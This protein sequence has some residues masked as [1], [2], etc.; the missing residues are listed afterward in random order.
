MIVLRA[1]ATWAGWL[2]RF[3]IG[4]G[5]DLAEVPADADIAGQLR[6]LRRAGQ[7]DPRRYFPLP[8]RPRRRDTAILHIVDA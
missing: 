3:R 8:L 6:T 1:L 2:A 5:G 4:P 7:R